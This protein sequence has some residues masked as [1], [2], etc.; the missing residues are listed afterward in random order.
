MFYVYALWSPGY[1]K[2]YVGMTQN[3]E[4]RFNDHNRGKSTYT[5]RFKPWELFF[6]EEVIE[7]E[8]AIKKEIY[9]KSG[10]GRKILKRKLEEWQSGRMRRS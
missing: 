1:D 3:W 2:I 10:W 5:N 8:Q 9:Y 4:K 7:K 6:L